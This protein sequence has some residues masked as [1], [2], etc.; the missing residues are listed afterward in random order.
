MSQNRIEAKM[1]ALKEKN[2]KAFITYITAGLPNLSA[3]K[4]IIKAQEKAGVD[5]IEMGI[6]FSDPIADGPV[7]QQASFDAIQNGATLKKIFVALEELRADG[8]N[9]PIIF[10]MYYNTVLHYGVEAFAKKC[11]ETGV[12]GLIIPDLPY[13][14]QEEMKKALNNDDRT[15]FIQLVSPVSKERVPMILKDARGFVYCVS[16]MGV[17]GQAADFHKEVINYL[18]Y[19]KEVSRIP[20]MMGFGIRTAA[21]VAPMKD[22]IDGAIVGSHFINL[23][24]ENDFNPEV[25][26]DY[27]RTF[28]KELNEL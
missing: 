26:A 12:D 17:T 24:R 28:K 9:V 20:V 27:C 18:S 8:V 5:V 4:E 3:T 14:E 11:K 13:E 1:E 15:I 22:I 16:S 10:M 6:P 21:D 19:V 7:I 23:L 2:E 25:A